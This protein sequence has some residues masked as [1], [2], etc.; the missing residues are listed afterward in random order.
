MRLTAI[1]QP[2]PIE[3][4][5]PIISLN[6]LSA[7]RPK[8][9]PV[10]SL[11]A[12]ARASCNSW[13]TWNGSRKTCT[14]IES[15]NTDLMNDTAHHSLFETSIPLLEIRPFFYTL[16]YWSFRCKSLVNILGLGFSAI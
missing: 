9:S 3:G 8:I 13:V 10:V 2:L 5:Y 12:N 6:N 15:L 7:F 1:C 16:K 11:L 4:I 14:R